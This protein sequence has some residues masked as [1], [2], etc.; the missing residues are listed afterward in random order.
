MAGSGL[1]R[2]CFNLFEVNLTFLESVR[3]TEGDPG[4]VEAFQL[5]NLSVSGI[6]R[7]VS[8]VPFVMT[9][10]CASQAAV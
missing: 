9:A 1:L 5:A 10:S 6:V 7:H 3:D 4:Q 8:P 2:T